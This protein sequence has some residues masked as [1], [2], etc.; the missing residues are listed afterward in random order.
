M[1]LTTDSIRGNDIII[2][3]IFSDK[4]IHEARKLLDE[5]LQKFL[6]SVQTSHTIKHLRNILMHSE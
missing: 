6:V 1:I 2:T 3:A 4:S 5:S